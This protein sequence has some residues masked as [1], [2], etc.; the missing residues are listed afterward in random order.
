MNITIE[1]TPDKIAQP[2]ASAI[3]GG[4]PVTTASRGGWCDGIYW[5]SKNA[6]APAGPKGEPWYSNVKFWAGNFKVA[7]V[8]IDDE[9]TGHK[10]THRIG[11]RKVRDGLAVMARE[12]PHRF[13]EI[14][15]DNIDAPCADIFL[16][17]ALFGEEKY[18]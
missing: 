2:F 11:P 16:Q 18:A 4:D 8:E 1:V 15:G 10:T 12:Y 5:K 9:T 14:L 17:C 7:I 3:E 6:G 13:A